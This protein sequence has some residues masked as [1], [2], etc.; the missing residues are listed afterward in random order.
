MSDTT[1]LHILSRVIDSQIHILNSLARIEDR[2]IL[3]EMYGRPRTN[4]ATTQQRLIRHRPNRE[5][6]GSSYLLHLLS[7]TQLVFKDPTS[8]PTETC[9]ICL[10][11]CTGLVRT[12][13]RCNHEFHASCLERWALRGNHTCPLC[14]VS[15]RRNNNS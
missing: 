12:I 10:S 15:F 1:T 7:G 3:I 13:T 2:L 8:V 11:D 6:S 4:L 14:R 9:S 5:D